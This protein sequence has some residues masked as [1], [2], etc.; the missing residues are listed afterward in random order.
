MSLFCYEHYLSCDRW[1]LYRVIFYSIASDL[2]VVGGGFLR[3]TAALQ[4]IGL[5]FEFL[6]SS[7]SPPSRW[8]VMIDSNLFAG[9]VF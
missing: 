2:R 4:R 5:S 1:I 6:L 3:G 9:N 8:I 7:Q